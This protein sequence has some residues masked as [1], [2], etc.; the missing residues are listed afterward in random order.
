[1]AA[2]LRK[3]LE[4]LEIEPEAALP[5]L[6]RFLGIKEGTEALDTS[7]IDG[8]QVRTTQILRQMCIEASRRRPLV[9]ALED[10]HWLDASSE[11]LAE[12]VKTLEGAPLMLIVTYRP[13]Y[14][15]QSLERSRLTQV[16]PH[17]PSPEHSRS[18]LGGLPPPDGQARP[19]ARA[20]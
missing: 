16:A 17:P 3:T 4:R 2:K 5:Y 1:M 8:I 13:G 15:P 19:A 14:W 9:I 12:M 7:R 11:A 20:G 10:I 6:L 18:G